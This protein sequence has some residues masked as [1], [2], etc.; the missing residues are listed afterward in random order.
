MAQ[1]V[2]GFWAGVRKYFME[3]RVRSVNGRKY[4]L[5]DDSMY[6]LRTNDYAVAVYNASRKQIAGAVW[7]ILPDWPSQ[8]KYFNVY[9]DERKVELEARAYW[10]S[11]E[12]LH[13]GCQIFTPK[14]AAKIIKW[15]LEK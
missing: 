10:D 8:F 6:G 3:P 4:V 1:G 13:L 11:A 2:S 12:H 9:L 7:N 15:A 5:S 14:Q